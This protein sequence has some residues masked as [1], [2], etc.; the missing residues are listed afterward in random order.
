MKGRKT[1]AHNDLI[2]ECVDLIRTCART[3]EPSFPHI[4]KCVES[5]IE[6][7]YIKRGEN[8]YNK[9]EYIPWTK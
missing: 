5:L 6:E 1:M 8:D 7:E 2:K 4:R 9:Y 3:F